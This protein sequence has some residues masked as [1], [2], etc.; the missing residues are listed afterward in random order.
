MNEDVLERARERR[1]AGLADNSAGRPMRAA[2]TLRAALKLLLTG[3]AG[4]ETD[5]I[6][7]AC[8]LTLAMSDLLTTGLDAAS[9]RLA[10]A[11]ALAG[12]DPELVARCR[13]QRGILLVRTGDFTQAAEELDAV[14]SE[15]QW[16]T[17]AERAAILVSR[18]VISFELGRPAEVESV[19]ASAV[20]LAEEA[21]DNRLR[22][23]AE[24]NRG[25]ARYLTGDLPG[26]LSAM[27]AAEELD[28][29]V[30]RGTSLFALARVLGEA[31]LLDQA[32]ETLD[33]ARAV[34]R[35]QVDS[36]LRAEIERERAVLLRL[37]GDFA[38]A[39]RSARAAKAAFHRLGAAD[40]EA[41]AGLIA[42]DCDLSRGRRLPAVL[43]G[44]LACEALARE[45]G[46]SDLVARSIPVAAEA[47]AR[48]GRPDV[49]RA[50]L[51]RYP[52][53]SHGLV[54][55]LRQVYAAAVT[56]LAA[57]RPP[58]RRLV[59]AAADLASSQATSGS[60]DSRAARKVLSL[61]LAGLDLGL[62]VDRGPTDVL[63]TLERWSSMGLPVVRSPANPQQ[64]ELTQRLRV[65]SQALRDEPQAPEAQARRTESSRVQRELTQL[66]LAQRQ[67]DPQSVV[68]P[69]LRD[70]LAGLTVGDRDLLWLF[71]HERSLWGVGVIAGRRRLARLAD[72]DRCLE[73]TRRVQADLR[74]AA[75]RPPGAL[76]DAIAASLTT[77]LDWLDAAVV[78]PW[79]L[80]SSGLV[81]IGTHAVSSVPWGRLPS[82]AGVPTT[83]ARSVTEWCARRTVSASTSVA[84]LTGP[85]L[86]HVDAEADQVAA[87]WPGSRP[88]RGARSSDLVAALADAEVVHVAAHGR[89]QPSS[90]LFSSLRMA[91]GD[92]Y[93]HELPAGEVR[94]RHVVL[95]ACDVGTAQVRPGDEPLGLA[96]TLL[97]MGVTAVV[98]AVAPVPD[99]ETAAIMAA[100]HR[101][102]AAGLPAD[103]A[104]ATAGAGSSFMV[105]GSS[106]RAG[107]PQG[108]TRITL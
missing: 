41:A 89:H 87:A 5:A 70:A 33:R 102:L 80:R 30:F 103:E 38:D 83:V 73:T 28:A 39:A 61:R 98:A 45:F 93:A 19:A 88:I 84:V 23:M 85:G 81:V 18:A 78:R 76:G 44:A 91:D 21:G 96:H 25:Y 43:A 4:R 66:G 9:S 69:D 52:P 31:G 95:S 11:R 106:W 50:A 12:D 36:I 58:R 49:A 35:P 2:R 59:A 71:P 74:A 46:D 63:A 53:E 54:I 26:A 15:P 48:L 99:D 101:K 97:A 105:L 27:A 22:F 90:P 86:E 10:E 108:A 24:H 64:A 67:Q 68:L 13:C 7:V 40:P 37:T 77:G 94:A 92:V 29:D 82:L 62:A 79:R 34:C 104:L 42:L 65:L 55:H 32:I 1:L 107:F 56:D 72:L 6:R 47:A 20:Q 3:P 60:L 100:Y 17:V 16:F 75:Y 51:R 8:L 14:I 57:G